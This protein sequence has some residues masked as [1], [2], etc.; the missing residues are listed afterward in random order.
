MQL[1]IFEFFEL[2]TSWIKI[3]HEVINSEN[4][5]ST[6]KYLSISSKLEL[7]PRNDPVEFQER[8]NCS[9]RFLDTK[10]LWTRIGA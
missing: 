5:N 9:L 4:S 3:I 7:S 10:E 1:M 8:D 2:I 6:H